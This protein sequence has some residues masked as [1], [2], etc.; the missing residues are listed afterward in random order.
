MATIYPGCEIITIKDGEHTRSRVCAILRTN[1]KFF[2]LASGHSFDSIVIDQG[3]DFKLFA[4]SE[5]K[6]PSMTVYDSKGT[7]IGKLRY[8][9]RRIIANK[10]IDIA[11]VEM[12]KDY[13]TL[14]R[15]S[16]VFA[17]KEGK[18]DGWS[19]PGEFERYT[20]RLI[21]DKQLGLNTLLQ[22]R[23]DLYSVIE[24]ARS[25]DK[26]FLENSGRDDGWVDTT[27]Q[28]TKGHSGAPVVYFPDPNGK[29]AVL[30]GMV[31]GSRQGTYTKAPHSFIPFD[32]IFRHI[33]GV[34]A[35]SEIALYN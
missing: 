6:L 29:T 12:R 1:E 27:I 32:A 13:T 2:L 33:T 17:K 3:R 30:V 16:I 21:H 7:R 20:C 10:A 18:S 5:E 22:Q 15:P 11:L 8:L 25:T 34:A 4:D 24:E 19:T 23:I 9:T 31:D 14:L 26:G 28:G 35:F